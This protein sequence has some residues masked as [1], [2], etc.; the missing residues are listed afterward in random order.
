MWLV[1]EIFFRKLE[2]MIAVCLNSIN[3]ELK[4]LFA[5]WLS[6]LSGTVHIKQAVLGSISSGD[7][8][9]LLVCCLKAC[10]IEKIHLTSL[11]VW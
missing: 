9:F 10:D 4:C 5:G 6:Q 7:Y 2:P 3:T 1:P 11:V 8:I